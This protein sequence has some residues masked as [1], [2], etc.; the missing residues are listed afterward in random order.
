MFFTCHGLKA[1]TED[2]LYFERRLNPFFK[3]LYPTDKL[4]KS[5]QCGFTRKFLKVTHLSRSNLYF[6]WNLNLSNSPMV[7]S[8]L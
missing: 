4:E 3:C 5:L 8:I 1:T 6:F 7:K 2:I